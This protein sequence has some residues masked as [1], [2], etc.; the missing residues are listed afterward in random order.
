MRGVEP[1]DHSTVDLCY[2]FNIVELTS[3]IELLRSNN[4]G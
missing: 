3:N 1:K 4:S 2:N